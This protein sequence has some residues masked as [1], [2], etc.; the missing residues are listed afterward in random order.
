[1]AALELSMV[2]GA[3]VGLGIEEIK[4]RVLRK[5]KVVRIMKQFDLKFGSPPTDFEG[6]Y[7]YTLIEYGVD[8]PKQ[9]LEVFRDQYVKEAVERSV[10]TDDNSILKDAIRD[11][12][13]RSPIGQE[14]IRMDV[15]VSGEYKEF[16]SIFW[17]YAK[18]NQDPINMLHDRKADQILSVV[19]KVSEKVDALHSSME[20]ENNSFTLPYVKSLRTYAPIKPDYF[21]HRKVLQNKLFNAIGMVDVVTESAPQGKLACIHGM[22]GA[23]KTVLLSAVISDPM[24]P[25]FFPDGYLWA[26]LGSEIVDV[27]DVNGI[28]SDWVSDLGGDP[29]G[30]FSTEE[31]ISVLRLLISEK[32]IL[33][34]I[35]DIWECDP[36]RT[37]LS[38]L[39]KNSHCVISTQ[40]PEIGLML[41]FTHEILVDRLDESEARR[42][43]EFRLS[44]AIED[45]EWDSKIKPVC[46]MIGYNPFA[47]DRAIIQTVLDDNGWNELRLAFEEI[48]GIEQLDNSFDVNYKNRSIRLMFDKSV[49]RL[50][51]DIRQKL[52]WLGVVGHSQMFYAEDAAMLWVP[53]GETPTQEDRT[54]LT[55]DKA[56]IERQQKKAKKVLGILCRKGFVSRFT[57][58]S[59]EEI[60]NLH[61]LLTNYLLEKMRQTDELNT[62]LHQHAWVYTSLAA[63]ELA[64]NS[65][66]DYLPRKVLPQQLVILK[67]TW[68]TIE[69]KSGLVYLDKIF[70]HHSML[71][72]GEYLS[73]YWERNNYHQEIVLWGKRCLE[74]VTENDGSEPERS[75]YGHL[76]LA[77]LGIGRYDLAISYF[78][79]CLIISQT[80]HDKHGEGVAL[81][82]LATTYIDQTDYE[83]AKDVIKK[84]IKIAQGLNNQS[85]EG[86][87]LSNLGIINLIQGNNKESL[88]LFEQALDLAK[89][90]DD[91]RA[92]GAR[93]GNIANLYLEPELID[94]TKAFS[95]L[96]QSKR[97]A[98][99]LRNF[100]SEGNQLFNIGRLYLLVGNDRLA[101]LYISHAAK[102]FLENRMLEKHSVA[103]DLLPELNDEVNS[104]FKIQVNELFL[105]VLDACRGDGIAET[106]VNYYLEEY[107]NA[108]NVDPEFALSIDRVILLLHGERDILKLINGLSLELSLNIQITLWGLKDYDLGMDMSRLTTIYQDLLSGEFKDIV[109]LESYYSSRQNTPYRRRIY[110][111]LIKF[112]RRLNEGERDSINLLQDITDEDTII[113]LKS[114]ID[115]KLT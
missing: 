110:S 32:K 23:G 1:M 57:R 5:E 115:L 25:N 69:G 56:F 31:L 62:A 59:D 27:S 44:R 36:A 79:E 6:L 46:E 77:Y 83:K 78:S 94:L 88:A 4:D 80:L 70:A 104:E 50:D 84:G 114:L 38:V 37:L 13:D 95:Y 42:L 102:V 55:L 112:T 41:G 9:I 64:A 33:I 74:I 61:P 43:V 48:R 51:K 81:A 18:Q 3:I 100:Q 49:S 7:V 14:L 21:I 98:R 90:Q 11:F 17:K 20:S 99:Q 58:T 24:F 60:Y 47:I 72:I 106:E 35:D 34:L 86:K 101:K 8:K 10:H 75:F 12:L 28:L 87:F 53:L 65:V 103:S 52:L 40:N 30:Y 92:Y 29:R 45:Q 2:I 39:G 16:M 85:M 19:N 96:H 71:L 82:N 113:F 67:R 22:D 97:I 108:S 76:G 68:E 93:L 107:R 54:F 63:T 15:D 26:T 73:R 105:L 89:Q 91:K 66:D 109:E 111:S